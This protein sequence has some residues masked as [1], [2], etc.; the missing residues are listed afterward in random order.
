MFSA[1][2][3]LTSGGDYVTKR[4]GEYGIIRRQRRKPLIAAVEGLAL[5][6]G[7]EILLSCD[8]VVASTPARVGLPEIRIGLIPRCGVLFRSPNALPLNLARELILTG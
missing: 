1:G 3:D 5:G 7:L 8:V 4:G 2:G 6:G